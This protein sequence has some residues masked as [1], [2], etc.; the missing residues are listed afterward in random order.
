MEKLAITCRILYN[1]ELLETKRELRQYKKRFDIPKILVDINWFQRS[2]NVQKMLNENML[3]K[4]KDYINKIIFQANKALN[5]LYKEE[6]IKYELFFEE[7]LKELRNG[8]EVVKKINERW[9]EYIGDDVYDYT[10]NFLKKLFEDINWMYCSE[11][12]KFVKTSKG[13]C[14]KCYV[15]YSSNYLFMDNQ[16]MLADLIDF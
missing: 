14:D 7:K 4:D 3:S 12:E 9:K 6:F 11:C 8:L 1:E 15:L 16:D 5:Y 13:L 2:W 10:W